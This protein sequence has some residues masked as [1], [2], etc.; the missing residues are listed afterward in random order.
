MCIKNALFCAQKMCFFYCKFLSNSVSNLYLFL[1]PK[2]CVFL[3]SKTRSN[4]VQKK[5]V[6]WKKKV[7]HLIQN[8]YG[9][10]IRCCFFMVQKWCRFFDFFWFQKIDFFCSKFWSNSSYNFSIFFRPKN[11]KKSAEKNQ[12]KVAKK[13]DKTP[14]PSR[15]AR[16]EPEPVQF[17]F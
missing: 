14:S 12:K 3:H 1:L 6:F 17:F 5:E 8:P 4:R 13:S 16:I 9:F 2:K 10:W 15:A 11:R 7:Q